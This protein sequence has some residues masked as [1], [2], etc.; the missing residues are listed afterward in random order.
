MAQPTITQSLFE[1]AKTVLSRP[2]ARP[3]VD[4]SVKELV[5]FVKRYNK[6]AMECGGTGFTGLYKPGN[7]IFADDGLKKAFE[8][9]NAVYINN[10]KQPAMFVNP[11]TGIA[12]RQ[13]PT[14]GVRVETKMRGEDKSAVHSG[15]IDQVLS[16]VG[17]LKGG[18][19]VD[20]VTE[21]IA[22]TT[23]AGQVTGVAP[24]VGGG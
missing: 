3:D 15:T 4:I 16:K 10:L 22:G 2:M 20:K 11:Q 5:D 18:T 12:L 24:V 21:A 8:L 14:F 1:K 17:T 23:M 6:T 9:Y 7:Q 19:F 13:H